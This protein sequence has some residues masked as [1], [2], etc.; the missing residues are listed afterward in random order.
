MLLNLTRSDAE[1]LGWA[2]FKGDF[3]GDFK[4]NPKPDCLREFALVAYKLKYLKIQ[5]KR[6]GDVSIYYPSPSIN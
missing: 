1:W 2:K 4:R 5:F 3:S 6:Q